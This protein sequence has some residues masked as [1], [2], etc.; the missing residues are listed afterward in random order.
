MKTLLF[1]I[2]ILTFACTNNNVETNQFE[3]RADSA[4]ES[5]DTLATYDR[6]CLNYK[7]KSLLTIGQNIKQLD[8]ALAFKIDQNTKPINNSQLVTN[9]SSYDEFYSVDSL[10]TGA[11]VG[12]LFFSAD[13]Q[14]RIFKIHGDWSIDADLTDTSGMEIMDYL[15][16]KYFPCLPND[17]KG[18]QTFELS[19]KNFI[20][21]LRL[22]PS[23]APDADHGYKEHWNL[24]YSA[25]PTKNGM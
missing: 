11:I 18:K 12:V 5:F 4:L 19:H 3:I 15:S 10:T 21:R 9:Y 2:C 17:F 16:S 23:D 8:P 6:C 14:G 24:T 1:I 7:G 25:E 22:Y 20:E 13:A